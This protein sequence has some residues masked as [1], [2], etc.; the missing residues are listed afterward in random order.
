MWSLRFELE[1]PNKTYDSGF[2]SKWS[3]GSILDAAVPSRPG[4]PIQ[5]SVGSRS[6]HMFGFAAKDAAAASMVPTIAR[7][8]DLLSSVRLNFFAYVGLGVEVEYARCC[9]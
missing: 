8:I 9:V 1:E 3:V 6:T 2:R 5:T 7:I 4:Q